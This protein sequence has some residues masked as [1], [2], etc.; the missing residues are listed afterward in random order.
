MRTRQ[1]R[2]LFSGILVIMVTVLSAQG[3]AE[4]QVNVGIFAPPPAYV[5][6]APPP[7]Y[8][9][10][11]TYVYYAP[12]IPVQI[13]FYHGHWYRPFEGRWYRASSYNGPW[14][15]LAPT[16]VPHA[17]MQL[18]PHYHKIPPGHQ[19]IP[20]GQLK[21]NWSKWE[22]EKHWHKDKDWKEAKNDGP[23]DKNGNGNGKGHGGKGKGKGHD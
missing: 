7:V 9:I 12:D 20:Y 4:V 1:L 19:K 11:G 2:L 14:A 22:K 15:Y 21:K 13:L 23:Y 16:H 8:V 5:V 10:P 18:P 6:Q 17:I 3:Y